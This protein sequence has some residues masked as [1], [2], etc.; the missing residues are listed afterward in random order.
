MADIIAEHKDFSGVWH[1]ASQPIN[2]FD[3]LTLIKKSYAVD[4]EI[5]PDETVVCDRSLDGR[6]FHGATGLAA[7][8]WPEMIDHMH[9]DATPYEELRKIHA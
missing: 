3:L 1:V 6:R 8:C 9:A 4:I 7:P 5:E 2:K